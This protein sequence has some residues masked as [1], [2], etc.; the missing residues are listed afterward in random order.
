[1]RYLI[2]R[3]VSGLIAKTPCTTTASIFADVSLADAVRE[4]L[5]MLKNSRH[6]P[7]TANIV[8]DNRMKHV[9][10]ISSL[11]R[12]IPN[13]LFDFVDAVAAAVA[14]KVMAI[15]RSCVHSSSFAA[16]TPNHA[17]VE[18]LIDTGQFANS[19]ELIAGD[20]QHLTSATKQLDRNVLAID[21]Q[22]EFA[23]KSGTVRQSPDPHACHRSASLLGNSSRQ[24]A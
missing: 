15:H 3:S 11:R 9:A 23:I 24:I 20:R 6:I 4:L 12:A 22:R 19:I 18:K 17:P 10:T 5:E 7:T 8:A 14:V 1:M 13:D 16:F 21:L 2:A